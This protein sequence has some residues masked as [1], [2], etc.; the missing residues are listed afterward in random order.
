LY[1]AVLTDFISEGHFARHIRR[2][3]MLYMERRKALVDAIGV[4]MGDMIE[5]RGD[6]AGMHL[7]AMLPPGVSDVAVS[8]KAAQSGISATPLST[9]YSKPPAR[10]GLILGYG[11]ANPR[12][13]HD[14]VC[15]LRMS[16]QVCRTPA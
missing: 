4:Q 10:G 8:R 2:M 9:C 6:E 3:R 12:Q 1:Q 11:G 15:K 14:G 16:M 5:V 13:I 7:V